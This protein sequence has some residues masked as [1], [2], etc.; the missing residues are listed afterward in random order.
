[1]TQKEFI[2]TIGNVIREEALKN[3]YDY[4]SAIIAQACLESNYGKSKLASK[5]HNYFGMKCGRSWKGGSVNMTTKEEYQ[6]GELTTIKD[7]FRTYE[8]MKAGVIGYFDFLNS[9]R[10]ANLRSARSPEEYLRLIKDDGYATSNNYVKNVIAVINKWD[11]KQYDVKEVITNYRLDLL[12][13]IA[14]EVIDGKW[15]NGAA[16]KVKLKRAG[17]NYNDVQQRVN[18]MCAMRLMDRGE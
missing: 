11:L 2:Q 13:T 6:P 8:N 1:M 17:Y 7:N 5:Y 12:D 9:K 16:R 18:Q 15:G 4:P 3:G 10:Y 14:L